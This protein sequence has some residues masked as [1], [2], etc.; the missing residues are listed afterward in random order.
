MA[1]AGRPEPA[2]RAPVDLGSVPTAAWDEVA[3]LGFDT[4]WLMGVWRRSP[5][6]VAVALANPDL[7]AEFRRALPDYTDADV[8]GLAVLRAR[9]RGRRRPGRARRA[10]RRPARRWPSGGCD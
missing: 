8:V 7:V 1:L 2:G 9:L 10:G 3:E 4:V 5:A 6:G